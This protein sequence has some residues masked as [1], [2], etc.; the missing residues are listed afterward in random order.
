MAAVRGPD[1]AS[2]RCGPR[3]SQPAGVASASGR[4]PG[5]ARSGPSAN[6]GPFCCQRNSFSADQTDAFR[7]TLGYEDVSCDVGVT[8]SVA[9]DLER[10]TR[11][12]KTAPILG[13]NAHLARIDVV[14]M[15]RVFAP[16]P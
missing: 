3:D 14:D 15:R 13:D 5:R 9:A 4:V 11:E 16:W 8:G 6:S 12:G 2:W 1:R 10:D 7:V